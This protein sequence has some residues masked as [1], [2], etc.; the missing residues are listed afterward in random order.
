MAIGHDIDCV[1]LAYLSVNGKGKTYPK[2]AQ[3]LREIF[4]ITKKPFILEG[5]KLETCPYAPDIIGARN[6]CP[7]SST[8]LSISLPSPPS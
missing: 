2:S 1:G 8:E 7:N 4:S 3:Q 6:R 5:L